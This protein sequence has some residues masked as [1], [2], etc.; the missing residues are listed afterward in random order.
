MAVGSVA[1][2]NILTV[3]KTNRPFF[4]TVRPEVALLNLNMQP[5]RYVMS[6]NENLTKIY[7]ECSNGYHKVDDFRS[8]LLGFLPLASGIAILGTLYNIEP[9]GDRFLTTHH[10]VIGIFGFIVTLG[11]HI[12]ELKG[13]EKCTQFIKL[14]KWI[15]DRMEDN[16]ISGDIRKGYFTEL[17][18]NGSKYINEPVASA[19]IYSIVLALWAYVAFLKIDPLNYIVPLFVFPTSFVL[20]IIHWRRKLKDEILAHRAISFNDIKVFIHRWFAGFDHQKSNAYFLEFLP[21][22]KIDMCFP[23]V[24]EIRSIAKFNEWYEQSKESVKKITMILSK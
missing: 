2:E 16:I 13:I 14:G 3:N 9:D 21:Y 20:G 18:L 22:K 5:R 12:Y 15:E 11:L 4:I 10:F 6:L 19:I 7:E 24:G 23:D 8:K 17:L 1:F